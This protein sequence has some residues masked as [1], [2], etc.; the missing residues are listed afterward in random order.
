MEIIA[1]ELDWTHID[2]EKWDAFLRSETGK[3]LIPKMIES[4]P[5][6]LATGDTNSILIRT[7][8]FRGFQ[9]AA[10]R[11]LEL[12]HSTPPTPIAVQNEY[13]PL[14]DDAAWND[15]KKL[16]PETPKSSQL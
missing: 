6:L 12:A 14:E 11:L 5:A 4:A 2:A 9:T 3:R 8:E 7:G 10:N 1:G 15:G 16:E 13:P